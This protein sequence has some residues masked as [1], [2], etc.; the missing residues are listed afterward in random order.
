MDAAA[1]AADASA[2]DAPILRLK[3]PPPP[4]WP[5]HG[6]LRFLLLPL[7]LL[8]LFLLSL[9]LL[10]LFLLPLLLRPL[11]LLPLLKRHV[12]VAHWRLP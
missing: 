10:P 11:L 2:A 6:G 7:L 3:Q 8:P 1:R 5:Q 12:S 9:L 4:Q